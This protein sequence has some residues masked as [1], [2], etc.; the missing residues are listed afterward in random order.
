MADGRC[1]AGGS[2]VVM[3]DGTWWGTAMVGTWN[4]IS[5]VARWAAGSFIFVEAAAF[6]SVGGFSRDL[7]ATEEIDLFRRLKRLAR[8]ERRRIVILTG[9]PLVTSGRKLQLYSWRDFAALMLRMVVTGGRAL[10][11]AEDCV[12]WYDGRR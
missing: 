2:T 5:R 3:E 9:H 4:L 6:R 1:L 10:R 8:H 11:R 12:V 7:Y